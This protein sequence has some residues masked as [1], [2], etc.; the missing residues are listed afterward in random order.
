M[1][2]EMRSVAIAG[3]VGWMGVIFALSSLHGGS[4]P[5]RFG[6]LGHFVVY[7]VLGAL[8]LL[9]LAH[10]SRGARAVLLAVLLASAYGVTD[11]FHQSF[12]PGRMPD[13]LDWLV[14]TAGAT[15]GASAAW[16]AL[17]RAQG[18]RTLGSAED[19]RTATASEHDGPTGV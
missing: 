6:S 12:V 5:G 11:E 10:P 15:V 9:A 2:G 8:Y 16:W 4:V 13:P 18:T 7:T 17:R 1:R 19:S 3:A 14:D